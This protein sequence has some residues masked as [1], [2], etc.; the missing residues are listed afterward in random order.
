M[1]FDTSRF[2]PPDDAM[3]VALVR[4]TE[5]MRRKTHA[6][7]AEAF[8][9]NPAAEAVDVR[10]VSEGMTLRVEVRPVTSR[11]SPPTWGRINAS[12]T[13]YVRR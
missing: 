10:Y 9:D 2:P 13:R 8:A 6:L 7:I 3:Q 1:D 12:T 11:D 4:A 5:E